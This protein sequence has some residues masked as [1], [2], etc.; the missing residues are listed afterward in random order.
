MWKKIYVA[1]A[2]IKQHKKYWKLKYILDVVFVGSLCLISPLP[3]AG[4]Q[5]CTAKI[6][7]LIHP[8]ARRIE[9]WS[10]DFRKYSVA[11]YIELSARFSLKKWTWG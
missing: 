5:A 8:R 11:V 3:L 1:I 9:D 10:V 2:N 7:N 4:K 6:P